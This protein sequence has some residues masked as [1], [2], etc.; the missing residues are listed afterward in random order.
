[1]YNNPTFQDRIRRTAQFVQRHQTLC[2]C[3][4]TA[5]ITAKMT[6][7]SD[8]AAMK[9]IAAQLLQN[10]GEKHNLLIDL[11]SFVDARGLREEFMAWAPNMRRE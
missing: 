6:H 4:A 2:A 11:T 7:D 10:E 8:V 3:A 5:V 9:N 1:M